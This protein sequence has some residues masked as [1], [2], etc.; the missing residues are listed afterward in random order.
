MRTLIAAMLGVGFL[1]GASDKAPSGLAGTVDAPAKSVAAPKSAPPPNAADLDK[2]ELRGQISQLM[3]VTLRGLYGPN[4]DDKNLLSQTPPGGVVIPLI[5]KPQDAADYIASLRSM[6][7]ES[8]AGYPLLIGANLYDLPRHERGVGASFAQLPSLMSIAASGDIALTERLAKLT[9]EQLKVMG[10][11]LN[12]GP[13]LDLAPTLEGALGGVQ[14]FG[15]NPNFASVAGG[16]IISTFEKNGVM[17][18]PMGFPGGGCN[19][20]GNSPATLLTPKA[21][22]KDR[23]L[24]P[25]VKAIEHSAPLL[26]VGNALV[27]TIDSESR[28]AS[29]SPSVMKGLL[30]DELKYQGV[31]V[32]GPIDAGDVKRLRDTS[33]AAIESLKAG[34]D[35]LYWAEPGHVS[36]AVETIARAV[37][38]GEMDRAIVLNALA[39]IMKLK[40]DQGL[41]ARE[42]PDRDKAAG[43]ASKKRYPE[44]AYEIERRSITLLQNRD[45]ILPLKKGVST[46][47]GVTGVVGV[48]VLKD[49]LEKQLKTVGEQSISSAKHVGDIEDFEIARLTQHGGGFRTAICVFTDMPK[50]Q[51][52]VRLVKEFKKVGVRVV[53]VYLGHP[54][55]IPKLT[56]ADAIVLA[57]CDPT[58]S[59]ASLQAVADVLLGEGPVGVL[60]GVREMK[61]TVGKSEPFDAAAVTK[62]PTGRLPISLGDVFQAGFSMSYDVTDILKGAEWDFGDG[63]RAKGVKVD[64]AYAKPGNYSVTLTVTG[65]HDDKSSGVFDVVVE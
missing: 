10:F 14:Y 20:V 1:C 15:S 63:K 54:R 42:M 9:A 8:R 59:E 64:H 34:A 46:S 57:Y 56:D 50:T 61:T 52:Q 25:Y 26:H 49:L 33:K 36:K 45:N 11:N 16:A 24:L 12:L 60:P 19:R 65:K 41:L 6:P 28:L 62:S 27:P 4:V 29:L 35:M 7:I 40:Q 5:V 53:V 18:M 38:S 37:E 22:L 32:A 23:D 51:G 44:E 58:M 39:R 31:I 55:A 30:R 13:A 2:F 21:L 47:V 17:A 3:L 48:D 43:L